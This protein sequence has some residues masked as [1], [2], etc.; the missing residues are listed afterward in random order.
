MAALP[1]FS[2]SALGHPA[3]PL[4]TTMAPRARSSGRTPEWLGA[5][6]ARIDGRPCAC[7]S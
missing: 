7:V 2:V 3:A 4:V 5:D 6:D 1:S